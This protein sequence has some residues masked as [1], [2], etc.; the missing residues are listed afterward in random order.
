MTAAEAVEHLD[1]MPLYDAANARR[2][3]IH[4]ICLYLRDNGA[5]E[6]AE[7]YLRLDTK[8]GRKARDD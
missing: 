2:A 4:T 6:L 1:Q 3:A 7:A 8:L 5:A